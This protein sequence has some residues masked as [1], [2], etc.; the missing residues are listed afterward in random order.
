M[1]KKTSAR[2]REL[3]TEL[4]A[5]SRNLAGIFWDIPVQPQ[6]SCK[7]WPILMDSP[8]RSRLRKY[9]NGRLPFEVD[10]TRLS[11]TSS[12]IQTKLW[13]WAQPCKLKIKSRNHFLL[14][15][16]QNL[17]ATSTFVGE[18]A[19]RD[20]RPTGWQGPGIGHC[21]STL[22]KMAKDNLCSKRWNCQF[23]YRK[24]TVHV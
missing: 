2:L 8:L 3:S 12:G 19:P 24:L 17:P 22:D 11:G 15:R 9:G 5:I 6:I 4:G 13:I 18:A 10:S 1:S 14:D 7:L 23:T 21:G 16:I 20:T